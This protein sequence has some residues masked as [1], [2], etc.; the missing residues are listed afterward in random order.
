MG[1]EFR[2]RKHPRL[3]CV[4]YHENGAYFI[5]IC[6]QDK[7]KTLSDIDVGRGLA[8]ANVHLTRYGVIADNQIRAISQRYPDVH[9]TKYVIMPNHIHILM[10]IDSAAGA[11]PRPTV[12]DVICTFKSLTTRIC[13]QNGH[14]GKLFQTSFYDH[15]VRTDQDYR[16]I[17]T[18]ID[19]NPA[20][21]AEDEYYTP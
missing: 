11:S 21:W 4:D 18:Y 2:E 1:K 10:V 5:T 13:N 17:W 6:T 9:I 16:D 14:S 20:K 15:I 19:D 7:I 3:K 8:P 12:M